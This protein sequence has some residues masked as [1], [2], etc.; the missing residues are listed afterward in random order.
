[1][2]AATLYAHHV[3][4]RNDV[5]QACDDPLVIHLVTRAR[6]GDGR[7]WDALV[8]RYAPLIWS[9]C[10]NYRLR[11]DDADDVSQNV[12]MRLVDHLDKIRDPAALPGWLATA[13]RREC[14]RVVGAARG[15]T[16]LSARSTPRPYRTGRPKRSSRNCSRPSA[17]RRCARRSLIC[18]WK[19]SGCRHARRGPAGAVRR[20]QRQAGHTYRQHRPD[21]QP[22]PGQ[23]APPPGRRSADQRRVGLALAGHG[24]SQLT[25]C[26]CTFG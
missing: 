26:N 22:L 4:T 14:W 25:P 5:E 23:D 7:A 8:E 3:S 18:R 20:D 2:T 13:S 24:C 17:M 12:W 10:R 1:M 6:G 15:P 19:A 21:P 11:R 16:R 9:I